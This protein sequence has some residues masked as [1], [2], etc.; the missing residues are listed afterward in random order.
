VSRRA[1]HPVLLVLLAAA[2]FGVGGAITRDADSAPAQST[3]TMNTLTVNVVGTGTVTGQGISC[4][5]DCTEAYPS[6]FQVTLT[7]S[8]SSNFESWSGCTDT[9]GT[10]CFVSMNTNKTVTAR[11]R[12]ANLNVE[13]VGS[14]TVTGTGISCP[15]DCSES[16]A[17]DSSVTLRASPASGFAF[18][19]WG[20]DCTTAGGAATCTLAMNSSKLARATFTQAAPTA[21]TLTVAVTGSGSVT[22]PGI[23]CPTDC[24]ESYAPGTAVTL[25]ASPA[26]GFALGS[27]GGDCASAGTAASCTLS[28]SANRSAS[29]TFAQA[30]PQIGELGVPPPPP[31]LP[32]QKPSLQANITGN[33][34]IL[35]TAG[36]G[37]SRFA[38]QAAA[39]KITCGIARFRCYAQFDRAQTVTATAKPAPGYVFTGWTGKC[40]G[41]KKT[42]RMPLTP[43]AATIGA[44]FA[45]AS[46]ATVALTMRKPSFSVRWI[47]SVGRGQ[48]V[49]R[50]RV[51]SAA[52]MRVHLRR[53]AGGSLTSRRVS[54]RG[55]VFLARLQ[56]GPGKLT[57][58]ARLFPG[59][60]VI[61]VVGRSGRTP[62]PL[63]VRTITLA[64]P[65]EGVVRTAFASTSEQGPAVA[66]LPAGSK[67][68]WA[69]FRFEVQPRAGQSL[70]V[71]W[72]FPDGRLLGTVPK[73]NRPE[74]TSFLRSQVALPAGAF[75]AELVAGN[76]IVQRLS[77]R[78][79]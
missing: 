36:A 7:P 46:G 32:K 55:G 25:N 41:R 5:G 61:T 21:Q 70:S 68:A 58:G 56:V 60:F 66:T 37:G 49:V 1:L 47:Q 52:A 76:R 78:I 79:G 14:G 2:G 51:S 59:G 57:R 16:Y 17:T 30:A 75:R 11:F 73:S 35:V 23:N 9:S 27:W 24:S 62:L 22:G 54:V 50:G 63:N 65:P 6:T 13:I 19:G 40:S 8:P 4:P 31:I 18:G 67:E 12:T 10:T 29:A 64:A 26:I 43:A 77:V 45:K 48:L 69:R 15:G 28:M 20:F 44:T 38:Q 74:V 3:T 39:P 33:G 71:R 53:P 34:T 72:Y 42:C